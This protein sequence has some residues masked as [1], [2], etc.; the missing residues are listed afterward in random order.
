MKKGDIIIII[1]V[2]LIAV[3]LSLITTL[4]KH[5]GMKELIIV[6][7]DEIIHEYAFDNT[8]RKEIIVDD[9]EH[10]N[11]IKVE[12]GIVTMIEANCPDQVCVKSRPIKEDGEMIVC[13]PNRLYVKV[14]SNN[15]NDDIDI[16]AS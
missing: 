15:S 5:S 11:I 7:N 4:T 3:S 9:G 1:G 2:L 13:L 16:I 12:D 8:F 6:H 10:I 14:I